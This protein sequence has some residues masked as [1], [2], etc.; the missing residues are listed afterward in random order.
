MIVIVF[1]WLI[2]ESASVLD[3]N[4]IINFVLSIVFGLL[5]RSAGTGVE[6][7]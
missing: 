4:V 1:V 6:V 7:S 2:V 5:L 3:S